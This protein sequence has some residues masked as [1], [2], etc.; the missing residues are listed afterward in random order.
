MQ[1]GTGTYPSVDNSKFC[2]GPEE[3][4]TNT[5]S[6][7]PPTPTLQLAPPEPDNAADM[8]SAPLP[9]Q[10]LIAIQQTQAVTPSR[11]PLFSD[12]R[13]LC[14]LHG[15]PISVKS[16]ETDLSANEKGKEKLSNSDGGMVRKPVVARESPSQ[17]RLEW[18]VS[19]FDPAEGMKFVDSVR[20][21]DSEGEDDEGDK[22][23]MLWTRPRLSYVS[24]NSP[25]QRF[26][27]SATLVGKKVYLLGGRTDY[28]YAALLDI[29]DTAGA[30]SG[31]MTW[32]QPP[33]GG[34]YM[35]AMDG[36]IACL[37]LGRDGA[38]ATAGNQ[39]GG[40]FGSSNESI[41]EDFS[42]G[43]IQSNRSRSLSGG[44]GSMGA[45]G[46]GGGRGK[47]VIVVFG[48]K[49]DNASLNSVLTMDPEKAQW[50]NL[51]PTGA[52]P[53]KRY[54]HC[55][56]VEGGEGE[57]SKVYIY[58]G[59]DGEKRFNDFW[60]LDMGTLTNKLGFL[61]FSTLLFK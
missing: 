52:G 51:S 55:A 11:S 24:C 36:H 59:V 38:A 6:A 21:A 32:T 8:E 1:D 13:Y 61:E 16:E 54:Y 20:L 34:S 17:Q 28:V 7:T 3:S 23:E 49:N 60:K 9:P 26:A 53:S 5:P 19:R 56:A 33:T 37:V 15:E 31:V 48:G 45:G 14:L 30:D 25:L 43:Y 10:P 57:G 50:T 22:R 47:K 12:G 29:L 18:H 39:M 46:S 42:E 40:L 44:G 35:S 41:F 58:G 27:C 4:L 2:F